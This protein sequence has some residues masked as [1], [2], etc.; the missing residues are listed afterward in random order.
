LKGLFEVEE[1]ARERGRIEKA[2]T[3][4]KEL[5]L[6]LTAFFADPPSEGLDLTIIG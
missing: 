5:V 6:V 1:G 2:P 3:L 4:S